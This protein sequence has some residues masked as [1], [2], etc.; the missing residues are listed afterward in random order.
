M[1]GY[2]EDAIAAETAA[3]QAEQARRDEIVARYRAKAPSGA[4]AAGTLI[5]YELIEQ[6]RKAMHELVDAAMD[7]G[8]PVNVVS[9][10]E[11]NDGTV[12]NIGTMQ[13]KQHLAVVLALMDH[14]A[15]VN[16]VVLN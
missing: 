5:T 15:Q 2:S 6:H 10:S 14:A 16:G 12:A 4:D 8:D 3:K 1:C 7:A 9:L 11:A 13:T